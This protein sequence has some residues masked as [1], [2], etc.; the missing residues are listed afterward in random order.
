MGEWVMETTIGDY[1]GATIG[2]HS[3][4][5]TKHQTVYNYGVWW[6]PFVNLFGFDKGTPKS[7]GKRVILGDLVWDS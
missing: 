4:F 1:I 6:V 3:P 7:T 5:P 2:I